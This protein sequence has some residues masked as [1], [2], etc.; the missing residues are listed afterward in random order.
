MS[1]IIER[2]R[3]RECVCVCSE[4]WGFKRVRNKARFVFQFKARR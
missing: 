3:E 4:M 2:E 1:G